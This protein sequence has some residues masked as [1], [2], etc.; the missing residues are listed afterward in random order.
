VDDR[1]RTETGVR[2][3]ATAHGG[4]RYLGRQQV[5]VAMRGGKQRATPSHQ[6][7]ST[8]DEQIAGADCPTKVGIGQPWRC[9]TSPKWR[10]PGDILEHSANVPLSR[11]ST[12]PAG[13]LSGRKS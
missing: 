11:V 10:K 13:R 5:L 4:Y 8:R 12:Q 6:H 1:C 2:R 9:V 7:A 3:R